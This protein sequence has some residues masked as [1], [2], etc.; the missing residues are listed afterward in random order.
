MLCTLQCVLYLGVDM[1]TRA[2]AEPRALSQAARLYRIARAPDSRSV[3]RLLDRA[4][5]RTDEGLRAFPGGFRA[6]CERT[7]ALP[8]PADNPAVQEGRRRALGL[9]ARQAVTRR[10]RLEAALLELDRARALAPNDPAISL[11]RV[12]VLALW[13]DPG[14][15]PTCRVRNRAAEAA[16]VLGELLRGFPE[17][18]SSERLYELGMLLARQGAYGE[19]AAAYRQAIALAFDAESRSAA[20]GQLAE[21]TMLAGDPAEARRHYL[22]ALRNTP[23]GPEAARLTFGLAVA[24]SRL[25]EHAQAL[26][27][28]TRALEQSDHS[29]DPLGPDQVQFDPAEERAVYEAIALEALAQLRPDQKA[30]SLQAAAERY[31]TFLTESPPANL[32][33]LA[34]EADLSRIT[35]ERSRPTGH[36][37]DGSR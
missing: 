19:A 23:K 35:A 28:A 26:E 9:L 13:E 18:R 34:A 17:L 14:S 37:G 4:E 11:A 30:R 6:I 15:L 3:E 29:L 20:Y 16:Q 36:L 5:A 33:R 7:Q 24:S 10:L 22:R 2:H 1:P 8:L 21:V 31:T 27:H 12:R 25:G 32:Y